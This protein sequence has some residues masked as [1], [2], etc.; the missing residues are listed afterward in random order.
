MIT[1]T[2]SITMPDNITAPIAFEAADFITQLTDWRIIQTSPY[3]PGINEASGQ[4]IIRCK[5]SEVR[6]A[7]GSRSGN[8]C[9]W[10]KQKNASH[11]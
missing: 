2:P 10:T 1:P 8:R 4:R 5:D 3:L 7:G 9:V 11:L 6:A